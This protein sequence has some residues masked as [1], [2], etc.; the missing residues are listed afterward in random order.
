MSLLPIGISRPKVEVLSPVAWNAGLGDGDLR[1]VPLRVRYR[2][3]AGY[4]PPPKLPSQE[5]ATFKGLLGT[6][7]FMNLSYLFYNLESLRCIHTKTNAGSSRRRH[8]RVRDRPLTD[9]P[10]LSASERRGNLTNKLKDFYL[11]AK[12]RI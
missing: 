2:P 11:K 8:Q 10:S 4:P 7:E 9:T 3:L 1:R 5:G 6:C 12:A